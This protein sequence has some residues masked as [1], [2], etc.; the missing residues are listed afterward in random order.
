MKND[1]TDNG[2]HAVAVLKSVDVESIAFA[3]VGG[4]PPFGDVVDVSS[5]FPRYFDDASLHV[6]VVL[7]CGFLVFGVPK[8]LEVLEAAA[9]DQGDVPTSLPSAHD[10]PHRDGVTF[11]TGILP[12]PWVCQSAVLDEE[13]LAAKEDEECSAFLGDG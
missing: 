10:V 11:S 4:V 8:G 2:R 9:S 13:V 5:R 12:G 7:W 1:I 6:V 3:S